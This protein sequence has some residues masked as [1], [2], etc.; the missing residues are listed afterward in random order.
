MKI[1]FPKREVT[2]DVETEARGYQKIDVLDGG[3]GNPVV[4]I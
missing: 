3:R 2:S 1:L 4:H